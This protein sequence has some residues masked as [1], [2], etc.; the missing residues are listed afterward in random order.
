ML[1]SF[2]AL[3]IVGLSFVG[4]ATLP[5]AAST[6]TDWIVGGGLGEGSRATAVSVL[7]R[8]V[9]AADD[10]SLYIADELF[11]RI[12]RVDAAG[13]VE[14][15]AGNGGYGFGQDGLPA[16]ATRLGIAE[17]LA[18]DPSG[19][20]F[21]VDLGNR[22]LR[23][24]DES[25]AAQ[26]FATPQSPLFASVP[27]TF[28]PVSLAIDAGGRVHVADRGT[29]V[30]WQ[31]D[32]DGRGRRAAGNGERGFNGDG[33]KSALA[34][35]ADPR[36]VDVAQEAI[37]IADTA[38]RRVRV[39]TRDGIIWTIAGDGSENR[40]A[41]GFSGAPLTTSLKPIDLQVSDTGIVYI[42]DEL[43]GQVLG[44][45][46][47]DLSRPDP[48]AQAS[49]RV[50]A[51]FDAATEAVAL[52]IDVYGHLL[53]ADYSG[54]RV[55][56]LDPDGSQVDSSGLVVAGSGSVRATG[57]RGDCPQRIVLRAGGNRDDIYR[58]DLPGRQGQWPGAAN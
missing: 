41:V 13:T 38:N 46:G 3:F 36:A 56:R 28:A 23:Y 32:A 27:G 42:L 47:I 2:L 11:N 25:G 16:L 45:S 1:R 51:R 8:A 12:R 44:V 34:Q 7:P 22:S 21:F 50:V 49:L 10:G 57:D 30:V 4:L 39:V 52:S 24:I 53:V 33:G 55:L 18:L 15:I 29:H 6:T 31:I 40:P 14:S 26:T 5:L 9:L 48:A 37:W 20:L 43:G 54:R 58:C 19:R 17:D 35:L